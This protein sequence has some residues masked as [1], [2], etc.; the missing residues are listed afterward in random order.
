MNAPF[1]GFTNPLSP[2]GLAM[3]D[4]PDF[5]AMDQALGYATVYTELTRDFAQRADIGGAEYAFMRARAY[6]EHAERRFTK[7]HGRHAAAERGRS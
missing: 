4:A 5:D 1:N 3:A 2:E 6:F 7:I